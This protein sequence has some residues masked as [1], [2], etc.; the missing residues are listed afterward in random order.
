M[1]KLNMREKN[2]VFFILITF[3]LIAFVLMFKK[4]TK[5]TDK[6]NNPR[7]AKIYWFIPDG[8]RADPD[9]F[10]IYKW[11]E[12]GRLPNIKKMM[13][14]G[15]YGYAIPVFP[16]HTPV[17]F[18]TLFTGVLP[19]KHYV[20]DGPMHVEGKPLDKVA[21]SGFSSA[22]KKVE[23]IWVT[24]EK[25]NKSVSLLSIPGSTPP[26]LQQ[27][28]TVRGRW[29]GWGADF[30][31]VNFEDVA[32]NE[33][34]FKQGKNARLFTFGPKL[35][36]YIETK[37]ADEINININSY[38]PPRKAELNHYESTIFA[39]I[40][41][42]TDNNKID[43]DKVAFTKDDETILTELTEGEWSDWSPIKVYWSNNE[44]KI[45]VD[46]HFKIKIIKLDSNGFFRIRFFYNNLNKFI[47]EPSS[48]ADD[49]N[50]N[51][52]PMVD[53]VDNFPPQLIYYPEDKTTF[54]EEM[55]MSF[56]WHEKA[57][58]YI[59]KNYNP[60]VFIHDIYSPNQMLTSRWWM[61][62]IDPQSKRYNDVDDK[63][64]EKLWDEV[65]AMYKELDN[66][67]G[68]LLNNADENTYVILSS[69]HGACP[70][71]RFV[72]LNNFFAKKGWLKFTIDAT[73]GESKIDWENSQVVYLK[74]DNVY[75]KPE[76]LAG[77]YYRSQGKE[78]EDLRAEVIRELE[79]LE[80][81]E[82]K[83][84]PV[85]KAVKWENV[86]EYLD[87]PKDRVG[88][89]IISNIPGYGWSEDMTEDL[90]IFNQPLKTGYKQ[91]IPPESKCI[92]TPFI[93]IGP[94]IKAGHRIENQIF[95]QDQ[96]PTIMKLIGES[97]PDSQGK[98]IEEI[99]E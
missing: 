50:Y 76:G 97:A 52:G 71:D 75:I 28:M 31:A 5:T 63:E 11:A 15:S 38:S 58:D 70:L 99:I 2:I 40:Y 64:R 24:L 25:L 86:E 94:N 72:L 36:E 91:A 18:A 54:L 51:V 57:S 33:N 68:V 67:L 65:Y 47:T 21:I 55:N 10:N 41:D 6:I 59:I 53:F 19:E 45:A 79:N 22:A 34:Q 83:I 37:N 8:M 30:H 46:T 39:Y 56:K 9:L 48:I 90:E 80:D 42:S 73:T 49:L 16:S 88:D 61:G 69:D 35:T 96:Y 20:A 17:N 87:L 66:N 44:N 93:I 13:E 4:N 12:E 84:K 32:N 23:P 82:T 62:Y 43:Y 85:I 26:E 27:G 95:L 78:Y 81:P 74:M 92:W 7:E 14:Q 89:L 1:Y 60:D 98:I 29:G 77:D 3:A